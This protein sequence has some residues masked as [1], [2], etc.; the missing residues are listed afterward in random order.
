MQTLYKSDQ[1]WWAP[2]T[3]VHVIVNV[4]VIGNVSFMKGYV[5]VQE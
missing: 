1:F 5:Q 2:D 4:H 3:F